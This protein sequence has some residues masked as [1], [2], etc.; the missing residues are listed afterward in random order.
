MRFLL[1]NISYGAGVGSRLHF[2]FPYAGHLK[3]TGKN[4]NQIIQF[5][6]TVD[7]DIIGLIEVD[8]GSFRSGN[9]NQAEIIAGELN[10]YHVFH[11]KYAE[12]SMANMV[13]V[14]KKQG[15]AILINR[16][17]E[18][19]RFHYFEEGVKRLV[20]EVD[21]KDFTIFLVH[22][23]LKFR[24]RQHQLHELYNLVKEVSKPVIVAGDF[25]A[26]W[27][28]REL[29]LFLAAAGLKSANGRGMPS[30]PSKSPRMQL[31]YIFHSPEIC[32]TD[33]QIPRVLLSDHAPLI[34][35]FEFKRA[36]A[37]LKKAGQA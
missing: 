5:V 32:T 8:C 21:M 9:G 36:E 28:D 37:G 3:T 7:A 14:M 27:G 4:L 18:A 20:I 19:Q 16:R 26:F 2:P 35:D 1:F 15:N 33:F 30:Y 29:E 24:H 31:D 6:K 25:N 17:I 23:S 13:P 12:A 22:L 11:S 10:H 34:W